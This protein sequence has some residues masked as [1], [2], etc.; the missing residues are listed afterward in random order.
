MKEKKLVALCATISLAMTLIII[1]TVSNEVGESEIPVLTTTEISTTTGTSA[2]VTS[3]AVSSGVTTIT[4]NSTTTEETTVTEPYSVISEEAEIPATEE[5]YLIEVPVEVVI[6]N[7]PVNEPVEEVITEAPVTEPEVTE[8][9]L[10]ADKDSMIYVKRFP[11]GTYYPAGPYAKGGSTRY[12]IDCSKGDGR[13]KGSV[14]SSYL[15]TEY[16]YEYNGS[17]TLL[18]LEVYDK[19]GEKDLSD[20][21]GFYYLDDSD[22][23]NPNVIDFFYEYECN[24][25]FQGIGVV[26]VECWVVNQ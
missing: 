6:V 14:A 4:T 5:P 24:C 18:Y 25:P 9:P 8:E 23:W 13:V 2:V 12:L 22:A 26:D 21:N 20:M 16:G 3:E 7:E 11:R 1:N 15:Y 10:V 17:R 19:K